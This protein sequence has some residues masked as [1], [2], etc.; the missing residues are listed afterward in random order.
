MAK[1]ADHPIYFKVVDKRTRF[2]CPKIISED[3]MERL[4]LASRLEDYLLWEVTGEEEEGQHLPLLK[5]R[6]EQSIY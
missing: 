5:V 4:L 1:K 2:W 6:D 3:W